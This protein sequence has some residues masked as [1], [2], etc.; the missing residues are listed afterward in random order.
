MSMFNGVARRWLSRLMAGLLA[1]GVAA[2]GGG[3]G[4]AGEPPFGGGGGGGGGGGT[5]PT[6]TL[7]VSLQDVS[8]NA[9]TEIATGTPVRARAVLRRAG[10]AVVN[11]I[12]TFTAEQTAELVRFDPA[13]G[14]LLTDANGVAQITV[15]SLG[16]VAGAGR[17]RATATVSGTE[18]T[19][20]TNFYA[21][22]SSAQQPSTLTLSALSIGSAAVSA[23]GTTGV[24]VQVLQ[25]GVPYTAPVTVSFTTSCPATKANI[26][27]TAVTQ[28]NGTA[29]A[30]FNDNGCGQNGDTTVTI[31]ASITTDSE[32]A[33]TVVRA[34]NTGSLRFVSVVPADKSITLRGQGGNGRQENASI[35]FQLVD[36]AG[37]GVGNADVCFDSTTY[38]GGLNVDGFEPARLPNPQGTTALCGS[39]VLSVVRYVKRTNPDGTVTVQVNS[40]TVPT[41]VRVRARAIY[42]VG[43]S[44]Q[45]ESYS[46]TLSI[47]NGLPLQRSMSLSVDKANIDGG[48]FDGEI[49]TLTVRLAD[50]FSNPV[51][52][53]TVVSFIASGAAVCTANNGSCQTTDGA[54]SCN[55]VSQERRPQDRR[56][57]VT[58]YAVGLEDFDDLNGD[59]VYTPGVDPFYD[60]GDVYV[61]SNKDGLPSTATINGDTDILVPYQQQNVFTAAGDGTRGTAHIRRSTVIY[62]SQSSSLGSPS[63]VI[64]LDQLQRQ[65]QFGGGAASAPFLRMEPNCPEGVPVP[66]SSFSFT[67]ED[68][69]GNPMAAATALLPIDATDNLSVGA[70]RP[71]AVQAFG[72]IPPSPLLDL[73]NVP[74]PGMWTRANAFGT[75]PTPH[76]VTVRGVQDKC[77]GSAGF[78][79]QVTSPR[80]GAAITNLYY[81]GEARGSVARSR[82]DVR[83]LPEVD[84]TLTNSGLTVTMTPDSWVEAA[85]GAPAVDAT[86]S[87]N[88]GDGTVN[89][90]PLDATPRTRTYGISGTKT[91]TVTVTAAGGTRYRSTRTIFVN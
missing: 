48:N 28:P 20:S 45:L 64:P 4:S 80:G 77:S 19:G 34:P 43:G 67:L 86:Y 89:S 17:V 42:P 84:F 6:V 47:S 11:E 41:P 44:V 39:D 83:Y 46:D 15:S 37:N 78:S 60:L 52:D 3:G 58:A 36:V 40:G 91:V 82:F 69:I 13:S 10:V 49:A 70:F 76:S 33:T 66:V 61:D 62:L 18:A 30:T 71:S 50:Q 72:A 29:V 35:T 23:Y 7:E 27:A 87:V 55:V 65:R 22:A 8:G 24:S 75:V 31:T 90:F 9:V 54:C 53:G 79:L 59:N 73:P 85:V 21:L 5:T 14:S 88:W 26:T 38:V 2:C 68:G 74:K 57:V 51:P 56:V 63:A 81:E 25:N 32:S 16:N 12:V 1:I